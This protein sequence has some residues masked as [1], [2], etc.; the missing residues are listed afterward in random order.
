MRKRNLLPGA[1]VVTVA[2]LLLLFS[3]CGQREIDQR[4]EA[5][6]PVEIEK[7]ADPSAVVSVQHPEL[8]PL[9][10]VGKYDAFPELKATGVVS[11]DVSRTIPVISLASGRVIEVRARLG[12]TVTKGQ[13]L[14]RVQSS[15]ISSAYSDYQQAVADE[16]LSR[17]QFNRAKALYDRGAIAQKDL[18]T[19]TDA[20]TKAKIAVQTALQHLRVLGADPDHPSAIVSVRAPVSGVITDQ[21]VTNAA[22]VQGLASP[23]PFTISD[24]SRVWVLCDVY[25]N[26]LPQVHLGEYADVR[27]NAYPDRVFKGRIG[28][29]SPILDASLRTAKVRL[30]MQ[31]P[32]MMRIGMFV[33]ASFR[34][35]RKTVYAAV[36][37]S[38]VLHLHDRDWVYTPEGGGRFK[39]VPVTSGDVLPDN[40]QAVSAGIVPGQQVVSNALSLHT[41]AEQ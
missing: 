2:F 33:T 23:N 14:L 28:N 8:F 3:S 41:T 38:A 17:A 19:S 25:E 16:V 35:L 18:E 22:G 5:P 29:I 39:R 37:A 1:A 11:A 10:T 7:Q 13:E 34:G 6:P 4:L 21:Q 36:P 30:E 15:D 27:L 31:N 9:A 40:M 26:D 32:G 12:D 24:L 20:E